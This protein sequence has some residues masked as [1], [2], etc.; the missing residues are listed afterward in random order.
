MKPY[1]DHGTFPQIL[2]YMAGGVPYP[3]VQRDSSCL[4]WI[5]GSTNKLLKLWRGIGGSGR[6]DCVLW[7]EMGG[8]G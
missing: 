7:R 6:K 2:P 4:A 5:E 3:P 1:T 8:P